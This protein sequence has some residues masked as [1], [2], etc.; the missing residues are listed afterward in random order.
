[1]FFSKFLNFGFKCLHSEITAFPEPFLLEFTR[2]WVKVV[3]IRGAVKRRLAEGFMVDE[4]L[5]LVD[6]K[7]FLNFFDDF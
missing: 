6:L 7:F 3:K 1:M 5:V 2:F 4:G